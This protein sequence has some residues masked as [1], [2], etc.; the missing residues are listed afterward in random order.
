M[1]CRSNSPST[2][3]PI[4]RAASPDSAK[5]EELRKVRAPVTFANEANHL[6]TGQLS[7][8]YDVFILLSRHNDGAKA[9]KPVG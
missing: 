7:S 1:K 8:E 9:S 4:F 2:C 5:S 3:A 6:D